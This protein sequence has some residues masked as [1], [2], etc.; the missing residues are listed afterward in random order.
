[1]GVIITNKKKNRPT[2]CWVEIENKMLS[3]KII[4]EFTKYLINVIFKNL[5]E[6]LKY[7]WIGRTI[8]L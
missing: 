6:S 7:I 8:Y 3:K 4:S 5:S 2:V 1:M